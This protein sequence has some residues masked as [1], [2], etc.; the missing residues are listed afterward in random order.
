[1]GEYENSLKIYDSIIE[2]SYDSE[3]FVLEQVLVFNVQ[4]T[5][6]KP[7]FIESFFILGILMYKKLHN[8]PVAL[9]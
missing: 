2:H 4:Q 3:E 6:K 7:P 8:L 1:M 5:L 9:E